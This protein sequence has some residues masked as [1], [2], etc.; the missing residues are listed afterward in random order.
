MGGPPGFRPSRWHRSQADGAYKLVA[1]RL[2][3]NSAIGVAAR[4]RA[5]EIRLAPPLADPD[6]RPP[7]LVSRAAAR[8]MFDCIV[9]APIVPQK[10]EQRNA[11]TR[12]SVLGRP[13]RW[14]LHVPGGR[15]LPGGGSPLGSC[16]RVRRRAQRARATLKADTRGQRPGQ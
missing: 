16:R 9:P 4:L 2:S 11:G 8:N 6:R 7:I 12:R 15:R 10:L 5:A 14:A 1:R 3:R 13:D